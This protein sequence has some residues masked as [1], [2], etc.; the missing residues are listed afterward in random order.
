[1]QQLHKEQGF[2]LVELAV[3]LAIIGLLVG[4]VM[5]GKSQI[6]AGRVNRVGVEAQQYLNAIDQFRSRF[7]GL[8]GDLLNAT[9]YWGAATCPNG[10]GSG[11]QTCNGNGDKIIDYWNETYRAW[12]QLKNAELVTGN[13]TGR[14]TTVGGRGVG[15]PG[16]NIPAGPIANSGWTLMALNTKS[17]G[18]WGYSNGSNIS[19]N[20]LVFGLTQPS[21]YANGVVLT[22]EEAKS[23]D[24]KY[25][26]GMPASGRIWT[27]PAGTCS[28]NATDTTTAR[29]NVRGKQLCRLGFRI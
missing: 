2:S 21:D 13:Y 10:A 18:E 14:Y 26:D 1:M 11:S 22:S 28:T 8:P 29:Y 16:I 23:L 9:Q 3:V 5:V 20:W 15:V 24:E 17:H 12:Q 4:G 19:I 27:G 25:D 6:D 7:R